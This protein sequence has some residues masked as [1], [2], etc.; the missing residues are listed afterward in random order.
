MYINTLRFQITFAARSSAFDCALSGPEGEEPGN[1][2]RCCAPGRKLVDCA[3]MYRMKTCA[4]I[5]AL[6][7]EAGALA[8]ALAQEGCPNT[9]PDGYIRSV[10]TGEC[11][12]ITPMV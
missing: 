1:D 12:P 7:I 9:C 4:L 3:P 5:L 8:P 10:Q 2:R 6:L 11:V